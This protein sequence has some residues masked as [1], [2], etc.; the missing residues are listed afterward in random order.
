M[1]ASCRNGP[2][3]IPLFET[4][5]QSCQTR[6][7][8]GTLAA[9]AHDYLQYDNVVQHRVETWLA[10]EAGAP[11]GFRL[12]ANG[13]VVGSE[14]LPLYR[15]ATMNENAERYMKVYC[16]PLQRRNGGHVTD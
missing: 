5:D 4:C 12:S 10:G 14:N 2:R 15:P 13:E 16:C 11:N 9:L 1:S 3:D 8:P 7:W 6:Q